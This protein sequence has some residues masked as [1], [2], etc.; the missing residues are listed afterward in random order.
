MFQKVNEVEIIIKTLTVCKL[1]RKE[2][3]NFKNGE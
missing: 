1:N 2:T 3:S